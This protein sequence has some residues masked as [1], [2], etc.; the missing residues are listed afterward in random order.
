MR[1]P[2]NDKSIEC[3]ED[4]SVSCFPINK[5][6]QDSEEIGVGYGL[7]KSAIYLRS[8]G[9]SVIPVGPDKK[10][11][12]AWKEFQSRA[13]SETEIDNWWA[14]FPDAN[15]A[16]VTGKISGLT[17]ID[18]DSSAAID[19]VESCLPDSFI[20]PTVSTPRG[21]RHYYF[22]HCGRLH[23]QNG[24]SAGL[25][26][27]SDGSYVLYP[28]SK[29]EVGSYSWCPGFDINSLS[30]CPAIPD[31]LLGFLIGQCAGSNGAKQTIQPLGQGR[32][33]NDLFSVA[34]RLFETRIREEV[35]SETILSLAGKCK[36]PF[37]QKEAM[38]KVR[39]AKKFFLN[40]REGGEDI[41][42]FIR[43]RCSDI[44]ETP[45]S[46]VWKGAV[47]MKMVTAISGD[48]GIG[49]TFVTVDIAG[50]VSRGRPFPV[51]QEP[52]PPIRGRVIYISSEGVPEAILKPRLRAA[53]A[54]LTK[55]DIIEGVY[56]KNNEFSVL[57]I[58][59]HL[60]QLEKECTKDP[61]IRLVVIDPIASF[62]PPR[63]DE[64]ASG[65][66]RRVMDMLSSF[67]NE[68][69]VAVVVV[70]H[71]N[72]DSSQK[73]VNRTSGSVQ[74]VAAVKSSWVVGHKAGYPAN[75]RFLMCPKSNLVPIEKSI[76]FTIQPYK[77]RSRKGEIET[78]KIAYGDPVKIDIEEVISPHSQPAISMTAKARVFLR[79]QLR[80]GRKLASGLY[81]M[82]EEQGI[83]KHAVWKAKAD[84]SVVDERSGYQGRS[85]WRL[86]EKEE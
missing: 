65:Q 77:Y 24:V 27:K 1:R 40:K 26:V 84:L 50:R 19:A 11:L 44:K 70:M 74:F 85:Y 21:G 67:A 10:P 30:E 78:A 35:I 4:F 59:K 56:D 57:D 86:P 5:G 83:G 14:R 68:T 80:G 8:N 54:N 36:P 31:A 6:P 58:E 23:S 49:K 46:W 62:L 34:L 20:P 29:T 9:F 47:P 61:K 43:R 81:Q 28:P 16:V 63:V 53:G 39:S 79:E 76:P 45:I 66:V 17:V 82:A 33:D 7:K 48:P 37:S 64:R 52:S 22:K 12:V 41:V 42:T 72:K 32:R 75:H 73:P 2:V 71:F 15:L 38:A 60:P 3:E 25:D 55:V 18:C 13:A 69:G 51:Y